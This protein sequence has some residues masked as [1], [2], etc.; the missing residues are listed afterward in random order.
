MN[1]LLINVKAKK[2]KDGQMQCNFDVAASAHY[3]ILFI[4]DEDHR[5]HSALVASPVKIDLD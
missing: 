1:G 3:P 2:E 5:S 4:H